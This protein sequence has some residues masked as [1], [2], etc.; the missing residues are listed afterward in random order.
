MELRHPSRVS[1]SL[2]SPSPSPPL[3]LDLFCQ[4]AGLRHPPEL[5]LQS[6]ARVHR[7]V[8]YLAVRF[9]C[10]SAPRDS[11]DGV[12]RRLR[13]GGNFWRRID[14]GLGGSCSPR[15]ACCS[16]VNIDRLPV[17]AVYHHTAGSSNIADGTVIKTPKPL[18]QLEPHR[19]LHRLRGRLG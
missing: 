6:D 16:S 11:R 7:T 18:G 10:P 13:P 9:D 8:A 17:A 4:D 3:L 14:R 12:R 15:P 5:E 1:T 2:Q 19:P